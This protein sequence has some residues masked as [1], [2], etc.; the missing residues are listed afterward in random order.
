MD[1]DGS[2]PLPVKGQQL[3]KHNRFNLYERDE[4]MDR[5]DAEIIISNT[6]QQFNDKILNTI[7]DQKEEPRL[8]FP[9]GINLISISLDVVNTVKFEFKLVGEK[10]DE[11]EGLIDENSSLVES[12]EVDASKKDGSDVVKGS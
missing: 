4:K 11:D 2:L 7:K 6:L 10:A 8:F 1:L 12:I 5:E 3:F 9:H